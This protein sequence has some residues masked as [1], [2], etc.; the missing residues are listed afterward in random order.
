MLRRIQR[1]PEFLWR[2]CCTDE[3]IFTQ[4]GNVNRQNLR[5]WAPE[6][7][8]WVRPVKNQV[9]WKVIV[10]AGIVGDRVMAHLFSRRTLLA[11]Y[12]V[13]FYKIHCQVSS[14]ITPS[15]WTVCG[16]YRTGRRPTTRLL[17]E[18]FLTDTFAGA[19][20]QTADPTKW[21]PRSPDLNPLDFYL[22][23]KIK[24]ICYREVPTTRDNMIERIRNAF[25]GI[26]P[27]ELRKVRGNY[28]RRLNCII[29]HEGGIIEPHL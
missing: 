25:Q 1:D 13:N 3:S 7:P 8:R 23:G 11:V 15:P 28:E 5:N 16:G 14:K 4:K 26:T 6:N 27:Q 2:L 29:E 22:W 21:P 9:R 18:T 10:W 12:I 24:D 19:G 17:S 20:S